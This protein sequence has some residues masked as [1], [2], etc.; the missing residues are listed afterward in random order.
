MFS[1]EVDKKLLIAYS[2]FI[3]LVAF[4]VLIPAPISMV[5][6]VEVCNETGDG[7]NVIFLDA[8][9]SHAYFLEKGVSKT[10]C[11]YAGDGYSELSK[12]MFHIIVYQ[13]Q[14][15]LLDERICGKDMPDKFTI[16]SNPPTENE[17]MPFE[18]W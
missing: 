14:R 2:I 3:T 13:G 17:N 4:T 9:H 5:A 12:R 15:I 18:Y 7:I 6:D 11:Y 16:N 10:I 8:P 1:P